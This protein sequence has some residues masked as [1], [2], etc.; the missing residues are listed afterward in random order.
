MST[1]TFSC[2]TFNIFCC[3]SESNKRYYIYQ[4]YKLKLK[5][6]NATDTEVRYAKIVLPVLIFIV[7][8]NTTVLQS[9]LYVKQDV[10]T[11]FQH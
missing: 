9:T 1:Q 11:E 7:K 4:Q 10:V 6:K 3:S 2:P 5:L 8:I